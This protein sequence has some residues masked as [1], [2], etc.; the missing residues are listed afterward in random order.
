MESVLGLSRYAS[1][2]DRVGVL[3]YDSHTAMH[4]SSLRDI[5]MALS[6]AAAQFERLREFLLILNVVVDFRS[7]NKAQYY[8][9]YLNIVSKAYGTSIPRSA[10]HVYTSKRTPMAWLALSYGF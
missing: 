5:E 9:R 2:R 4:R 10:L 7:R 1:L 6:F 3:V 8:T